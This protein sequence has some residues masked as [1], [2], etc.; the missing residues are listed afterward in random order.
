MERKPLKMILGWICF[1]I[2]TRIPSNTIQV[3]TGV[4][5]WLVSWAGYYAHAP[6]RGAHHD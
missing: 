6:E 5:L 2:W 1:Q 4:G 3:T